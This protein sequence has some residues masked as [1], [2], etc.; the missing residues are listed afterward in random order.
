VFP[1]RLDGYGDDGLPV[2]TRLGRSVSATLLPLGGA[3]RL[4]MVPADC[5]RVAAGDRLHWHRF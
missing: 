1:V 4:A 2:L 3:D 5:D